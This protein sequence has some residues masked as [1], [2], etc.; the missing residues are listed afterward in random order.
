MIYFYIF[1]CVFCL[2]LSF[3]GGFLANTIVKKWKA[4]QVRN[5]K[6]RQKQLQE[7]RQKQQKQPF[8]KNIDTIKNPQNLKTNATKSKL[9]NNHNKEV[10]KSSS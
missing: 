7:I 5:N 3:V 1:L 9:R 4:K 8:F 10:S 6:K 2:F